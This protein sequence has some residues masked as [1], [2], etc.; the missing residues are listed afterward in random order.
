[1]ADLDLDALERWVRYI[2]R[3][4]HAAEADE[5][6][7]AFAL[8]REA[9][10]ARRDPTVEECER[11]G[12]GPMPLYNG[13]YSEGGLPNTPQ[14]R[15]RFEAYMRGHC[16]DVGKYNESQQAYDSVS[17]RMLYGV[18]RDRGA[19][20]L[21]QAA[22]NIAT[23]NAEVWK[24][25]AQAA[26]EDAENAKRAEW[27]HEIGFGLIHRDSIESLIA[28][29][30]IQL[31]DGDFENSEEERLTEQLLGRLEDQHRAILNAAREKGK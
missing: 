11:A 20:G 27:L 26:K 18:W 12:K 13:T 23:A 1:M 17:V 21:D 6:I 31:A 8:A 15:E 14:E 24:A 4:V 22:I 2:V 19:L 10:A 16:W 25:E 30:N 7:D 28:I 9:Q 5:I 3:P 29:V